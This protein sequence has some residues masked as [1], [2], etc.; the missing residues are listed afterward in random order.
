MINLKSHTTGPGAAGFV[1]V[2][3]L[4]LAQADA[5]ERAGP[6]REAGT[7]SGSPRRP[8]TDPT[9]VSREALADPAPG[10]WPS[11]RRTLDGHG[12]S[13]LKLITRENVGGLQLAWTWRMEEGRSESTPLVHDGVMYLSNPNDVTQALRADTGERIWEYRR[14][15]DSRRGGSTRSLA[16]LGDRV[17]TTTSDGAVVALDARTG[18]LIWETAADPGAGVLRAGGLTAAGGV[19]IGGVNGCNRFRKEGCFITAHDPDTGKE[20][21]RRSTIA[22]PGD[23][24][25]ASWGGLAPEL[26]GGG[27]AWIPGSYDP[28]LDVF[29]IGTAQAK[30]FFPA[31]RGLTAADAVLYTNS[32]LALDPRTGKILWHFQ[33]VPAESLDMDSVFERVLVDID[34]RKLVFTIGKDGIL[35]KLDRRS[36]AFV[37]LKETM[38]QNIF[39]SVDDKTGTVRY[40]PDILQA[41]VGDW[42]QGCPSYMGGHNWQATAYVPESTALIIP[43][44]Q[45]CFEIQALKAELKEGA[46]WGPSRVRYAEMP[47]SHGNLGRL[48]SYDLKTMKELWSYRQRAMFTSGVVTTAGGLAFVGDADRY[49]K[50]FDTS[51][52]KVLWQTRLAGP[53]HGFPISYS[54]GRDQFI[55][56]PTGMGAFLAPILALSP[57]IHVPANANGLYVFK[58]PDRTR[59]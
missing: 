56:V 5:I 53:V 17:F 11:W 18:T 13:P 39:A 57:E 10:D 49:F 2:A 8:V 32:T 42:I 25:D 44:H 7:A 21:W 55:A 19:L 23:P 12:Y 14:F 47:G 41:K 51:T 37:G 9:P 4:A 40:R 34:G 43:L 20:L 6:Q 16:L 30:P 59:R 33:H 31:S 24:N 26:R 15:R 3:L 1:I 58:L 28:Q 50:A 27:D 46:A 52:G 48:T 22:L 54:V 35:W 38:V 29:Y 45:T 36:G